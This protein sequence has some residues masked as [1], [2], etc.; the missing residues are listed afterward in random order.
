M[1]ARTLSQFMLAN[2]TLV[3]DRQGQIREL[4]AGAQ[5]APGEVVMTVSDDAN[6]QV[7]AQLIQANDQQTP[8]NI[9]DE[10]AQILAQLEQGVDPTLNPD[11][12]TAAGGANGSSPTDTGTIDMTLAEVLAQTAFDTHGLQDPGL[13]QTQSL[14][15]DLVIAQALAPIDPVVNVVPLVEDESPVFV[16]TGDEGEGSETPQPVDDYEFFYN[17][18]SSTDDVIGTVSAVDPEGEAVTYS[19]VT[20]VYGADDTEKAYPYFVIDNDGNIRLTTEGAAAFTNDYEA[21][22]NVHNLVVRA[23]EVDEQGDGDVENY[24]DIN[25]TLNE[26]DVDEVPVF[27]STGDEGE[28]SETPQPVDDYEFFYNEMSSTDDVIGTV[29]AVDPEGEAVTYSIVTNVYGAD[30]TEKAYPYFVI[31]NDGNIRLTTEGAAAFTNDYEAISNVHNL[32]VRATEVDE[33]G[34]GDV[35]NYTDINVTLNEININEAPVAEDFTVTVS[36]KTE[37]SIVFDTTVG[38]DDDHISDAEVDSP[39]VTQ[40]L[41]VVITDLPDLGELRYYTSETTFIVL[42]ESYLYDINDDLGTVDSFKLLNPDNIKYVQDDNEEFHLSSNKWSLS[43]TNN[44]PCIIKLDNG[45]QIT[46]SAWDVN[47]QS[48]NVVY[49]DLD[50]FQGVN[51]NQGTGIG[52]EGGGGMNVGE[53][54]HI[55]LSENPLTSINFI[56][57]GVN[58]AY[59]NAKPVTVTYE[60]LNGTLDDNNGQGYG[61]FD[62]GEY[63]VSD[64]DNPVVG[65]YF[66]SAVSNYVLGDLT[67]EQLITSEDSFKYMA[68]DSELAMSEV[69][70]VTLDINQQVFP[71]QQGIVTAETGSETLYGNDEANIFT[72]LDSALDNSVDTVKNFTVGTDSIEIGSILTDESTGQDIAQLLANEDIVVSTGDNDVVLT[73]THDAGEQSIVIE[74]LDL[75]AYEVGGSFDAAA[76]LN[77]V[78]KT[79]DTTS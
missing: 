4:T 11:Q 5:P 77:D 12:A 68:V 43:D 8:L 22:S 7:Q 49:P 35:E 41:Y 29:S 62:E 51:D 61:Y 36:D 32:V 27:V 74:N 37:V 63:I 17:E 38:A 31:D 47:G 57:D 72:W 52:T 2:I 55:D 69:A 16:S 30:D 67:G 18:M 6:P 79:T 15:I 39:L 23:T 1:N 40:D 78:L 19:I 42:D 53:T 46:V 9:D 66:T 59:V 13:S 58:P 65:V 25:V 34:D 48:G 45:A 33:Q 76:F 54:L 20:N 3:I 73:V 14:A 28:G 26:V 10:V 21:I 56:L 75:T 60:L 24:T 70:T 50:Y 64:T 71:D 44:N